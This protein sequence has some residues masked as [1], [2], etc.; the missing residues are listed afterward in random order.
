M[1]DV[2][3][4]KILLN[5]TELKP[6]ILSKV[7]NLNTFDVIILINN[8]NYYQDQIKKYLKKNNSNSKKL[9]FDVWNLLS[10]S[11]IESQNWIYQNI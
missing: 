7:R 10:Q 6:A 11:Y 5:K 2:L 4:K 3:G 8:H 1:H 9:I